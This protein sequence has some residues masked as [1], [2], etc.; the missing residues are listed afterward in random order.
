MQS[1]S[2]EGCSFIR[3]EDCSPNESEYR[4]LKIPITKSVNGVSLTD[5]SSGFMHM[6]IT[7]NFEDD[8]ITVYLN[9]NE[10]ESSSVSNVFGTD[11]GKPISIPTFA[12]VG[13]ETSSFSY[14]GSIPIQESEDFLNGPRLDQFFTPWIVGGGWTDGFPLKAEASKG[15]TKIIRN[16]NEL[17]ANS[18]TYGP[19]GYEINLSSIYGG[20][21]GPSNG[22]SSGLGGHLGSLKIYSKPLSNNEVSVNYDAHKT[23]FSNIKTINGF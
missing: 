7:F 8:T 23:F 9:G 19:G 14:P 2:K 20:F 4:G 22:M 10:L 1:F 17:G 12:K 15:S 5:C 3:N 16:L 13:G 6:S 18:I 21:S 11:K